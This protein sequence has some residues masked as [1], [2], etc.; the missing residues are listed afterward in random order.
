MRS[1]L[2][3]SRQRLKSS[4]ATRSGSRSSFESGQV[5]VQP[6]HAL[7]GALRWSSVPAAA[8]E[9]DL[10]ARK[11]S[12]TH[13]AVAAKDVLED[14]QLRARLASRKRSTAPSGSGTAARR[15]PRF[16]DPSRLS[17]MPRMPQS[18]SDFGFGLFRL[19][20]EREDVKERQP[21]QQVNAEV[22]AGVFVGEERRA[23]TLGGRLRSGCPG[24]GSGT[25][26]R[27]ESS[28]CIRTPVHHHRRDAQADEQ[29]VHARLPSSAV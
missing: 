21:E 15:R 28:E 8:E 14:P 20:T 29:P 13:V 23:S 7:A 24:S 4:D 2:A 16:R 6:Q 11:F 3:R 1:V 19:A 9:A 27:W 25:A 12:Q 10:P 17:E 18:V 26:L 22:E 5:V